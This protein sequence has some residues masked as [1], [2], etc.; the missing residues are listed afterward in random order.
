[1]EPTDLIEYKGYLFRA[2][3]MDGGP[4]DRPWTGVFV[5]FKR[6]GGGALVEIAATRSTKE[7]FAT[8]GFATNAA[9][10]EARSEI[11]VLN[12]P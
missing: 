2:G 6:D 11:D 12:G 3:A 9:T 4:P 7:T 8:D 10:A 1:M 5:I